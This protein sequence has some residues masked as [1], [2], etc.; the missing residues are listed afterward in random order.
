MENSNNESLEI[1]IQPTELKGEGELIETGPDLG[2][3]VEFTPQ[4]LDKTLNVIT[5]GA[6]SFSKVLNKMKGK[7]YYP[8]N[9]T[10]EFGIGVGGKGKVFIAEASASSS[11]KISLTWD[12]KK[13]KK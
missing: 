2:K 12:S 11:L 9:A 1:F 8:D 7:K 13:S 3:L 10:L 4:L 6:E 5:F